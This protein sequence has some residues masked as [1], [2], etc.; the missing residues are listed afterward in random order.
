[1]ET[2]N[3]RETLL[4]AVKS[5]KRRSDGVASE[6]DPLVRRLMSSGLFTKEEVHIYTGLGRN[7]IDRITR[8]KEPP[9]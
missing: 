7:T 5:W 9:A 4:A 1:M 6:R 3:E 2:S 8:P